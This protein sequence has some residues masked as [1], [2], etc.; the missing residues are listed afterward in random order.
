LWRIGYALAACFAAALAGLAVLWLAALGLLN[1]PY[2]PHARAI[3]LH[4]T[5]GVAQ[6][7]FAS[8]AGAGALVAL[9]MAY[10]R[11]RVTEAATVLDKERWQATAAQD[12]IRL[13]NERF[14]AIA[15]QIGS[16]QAA[17]RLAGVHAMAGLA[18]DWDENRQTCIDVLCAYL[19]MPYAR[20]PTGGPS[21]GDRSWLAWRGFQEVRHTVIRVIA[22]HLRAGAVVS[23]RGLSFDFTGVV[24]D[25]GSFGGAE[26]SGGEV[27][28]GGATFSGG[29]VSFDGATFSGGMVRF[30]G[31]TF[32]GGE[33]SFGGAT[34][35]GG[36][37][38]LF[39][40]TFSAGTVSLS[41]VRFSGGEV[42][43][44]YAT[45]SGGEVSFGD[46]AFSGGTVSFGGGAFSGGAVRFNGATFSSGTVRFNGAAF[47]G[48]KVSFFG[49]TFSGGTVVFEGVKFSGTQ[50]NFGRAEFSG[51]KVDFTGAADWSHP[52][53][54]AWAGPPPAEVKLPAAGTQTST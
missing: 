18:D 40:A 43:F 31:A 34:F 54:F 35:S 8:V 41:G 38:S 5:V 15:A 48:G 16:D 14:T 10:R 2:L 21:S 45:F 53:K 37:V 7:V 6:L 24:F 36:E 22:A 23:W 42:R 49:A 50:V 17:V 46:A 19:R 39:G 9:V 26:F 28:F 33:V 1:F 51:G 30:N 47:S 11:Q 32:S 12:R 25:G 29:E 13:L 4:D 27:S 44:S 20:E 3:S 52:P